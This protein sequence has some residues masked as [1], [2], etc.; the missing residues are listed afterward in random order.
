MASL[1]S[2]SAPFDP[3]ELGIATDSGSLASSVAG[4]G[5]SFAGEGEETSSG[6]V[7]TLWIPGR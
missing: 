4:A 7:G 3:D 2:L 5:V 6:E 1:L